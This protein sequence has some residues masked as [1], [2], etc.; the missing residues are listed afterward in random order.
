MSISRSLP[1]RPKNPVTRAGDRILLGRHTL[2]C[3]D[4]R[5]PEVWKQLLAGRRAGMVWTDPPYG[6]AYQGGTSEKLT[7]ENDDLDI[8]ALT[9]FLRKALS[10]AWLHS[11]AGAAWYVAAP[12]GPQFLAFAQVCS[13]LGVWRQ[14][15][16]WVKHTF[17][18]GRSDYHYRHE[19][20][21]EGERP[22]DAD[23]LTARPTPP[24][25]VEVPEGTLGARDVLENQPLVYG[26]KPGAGHTWQ[27]GR[28]QDTVFEVPKP[29]LNRDHPTMKPVALIERH[30][31]NSSKPEDL[32]VDAFGGSGSTLMAAEIT[33]R[34]SALI[35][36]APAYC[37]VIVQRWEDATGLPAQR[38]KREGP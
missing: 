37:D 6:V 12:H 11:R 14:T 25:D 8:P 35:E 3:G 20:V 4:S 36:L 32:I 34:S 22:D 16:V 27:G 33:G 26:W 9:V 31:E 5:D 13:E 18:L 21:L 1:R 30:I 29:Q 2:V 28:K 17:A 24:V 38:P 7:I 23:M 19:A 15:L 10:L